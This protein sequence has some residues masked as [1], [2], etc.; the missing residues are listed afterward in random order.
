MRRR[1]KLAKAPKSVKAPVND[2]QKEGIIGAS[3]NRAIFLGQ[4]LAVSE[5]R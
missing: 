5:R 2:D 3:Y 1:Q 4:T